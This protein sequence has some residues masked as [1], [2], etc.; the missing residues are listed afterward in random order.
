MKKLLLTSA[1]ISAFTGTSAYANASEKDLPSREEMWKMIQAQQTQISELKEMVESTDEKVEATTAAVEETAEQ[2]A[3]IEPNIGG[4][5]GDNNNGGSGWFNKTSIFGYGELHLNKGS[6]IDEI[7]LHRFIIGIGH[8]FTDDLRLVSEIEIEHALVGEGEAG[9]VEIEQAFV[10]YDIN[11]ENRVKGGVFLLPVGILNEVHEPTT[12]FGVERNP[13]ETAIIPVGWWAGG[14]S[15]S[16]HLGDGFSYDIGYHSGLNDDGADGIIR[17]ARQKVSEA[18]AE[19]GATTGRIKYTGIP[20]L[21]LAVTGQY[22]EDISQ[23]TGIDDHS[24]TLVETHAVYNSG[25]FG[26]RALYAQWDIDGSEVAAL[27]RDDQ[28]GFY[29]EPS[30]TFDVT[31]TDRLGFFARY[32]E[33]D[34]SAGDDI[35]SVEKQYDVGFNYWPHPDVVLK[36]DVAF[37]DAPPG[38]IDDEIINLGIGFTY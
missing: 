7:D 13:I 6:T 33:Y 9:E 37:V 24:A 22:Q 31:E 36:A 32:N 18:E 25:G 35:D 11:D 20:G 26:L 1:L 5:N 21:E 16:G 38:G 12:F 14:V 15:F 27:G 8:E 2:V 23:S 10:E 30:Y 19:A 3:A 28:Y 17:S 29:V 34:T 4:Y